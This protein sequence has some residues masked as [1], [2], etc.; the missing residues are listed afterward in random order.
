[1]S[2]FLPMVSKLDIIDKRIGQ[3]R[4]EP[5]WAQI[6]Y[7]EEAQRQL[8]TMGRIRI[9]VLK[10]RQLGISTITEA[11]FF[12]LCFIVPNYRALVIAHEIEASQNLLAM[13]DLFW[14]TS[15][16]FDLYNTKYLSRNDVVWRETRS[17]MRIST[18]GKKGTAGVGRSTTTHAVHASEVGFW[19]NPETIM[20]G[21]NQA[22]PQSPGTA[23]I[24]ESTANGRGNYFHRQWNEAT[25]GRSEYTPLFFPWWKHPEYRASELGL[26][27]KTLGK[28]DEDEKILRR[29][30]VDDN[31]LAWRRWAIPNKADGDLTKFMQEYPAS[32]E[33]AFIA[34]G[35][36]VFPYRDLFE[37][38]EPQPGVRGELMREG[39][40]VTFQPTDTGRLTI[41]KP[42]SDDPSWGQYLVTGD[43]THM[44][45]GGDPACAQ[46]INRRTLEQ[47]AEWRGHI[48]APTFGEELFRL[49]LFYNTALVSCEVEKV[50]GATI[51][52]LIAKKYPKLWRNSKLDQIPGRFSNLHGW[53]T[54]AA[55]KPSMVH[56]LLKFVVDHSITIHSATLFDEMQDFVALDNGNFGPADEERG[57]DDTVMAMA[58]AAIVHM[59]EGPVPL[60]AGVTPDNPTP[61]HDVAELLGLNQPPP[62]EDI[63]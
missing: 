34:S 1:M 44:M 56:M 4:L 29:L 27:Y 6:Q 16:F 5:N 46:V 22:I 59:L 37:C 9:I 8:Q 48:D 18:A 23:V 30:G 31:H 26:A 45:Q 33:E 14:H 55:S 60:Y 2:L 13:T 21:L 17:S 25:I 47:V 32:P 12:W 11:M 54:T 40:T 7:L 20:L 49:G 3:R 38:Y 28:L 50:G 53:H 43:P 15:P 41:F 57:H 51:G 35:Q 36:N 19:D 63:A 39:M 61:S 24:L 58:Q 42:P 10:A 62:Y 52:S